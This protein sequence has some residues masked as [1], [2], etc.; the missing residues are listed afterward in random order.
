MAS[1]A[2]GHTLFEIDAELDA[3][4]EEI[5]T[6]EEG[7]E[8]VP[9]ELIARFQSFCRAH[10]DKVDRVGRFIRMMEAREQHCRGEA[11]RLTA[12]ARAAA[13]RVDRTKSMVLYY[14]MSRQQKKIEGAQF[15]LRV[16][17]N[18]Q[19][20][21]RITDDQ[22]LPSAYCHIG[23]KIEGTLY[24][25]ILA[26]LPDGLAAELERCVEERL[27]NNEAIKA[28]VARQEDIPGAEVKRGFHV[29][30]A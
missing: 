10:G 20:S 23:V 28:A 6:K 24:E 4:F 12:R 8:P 5:E 30:V 27:P 18:S 22:A 9:E 15:T 7:G 19:D 16:Q 2:E 17:K 26:N 11:N 29:R 3:L 14:L 25:T 13:G 21:V 1:I